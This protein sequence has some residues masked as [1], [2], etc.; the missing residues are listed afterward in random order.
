MVIGTQRKLDYT[1][2]RV[3]IERFI[4]VR[5]K[6]LD[7]GWKLNHILLKLG[8]YFSQIN[9]DEHKVG[10]S[11]IENVCDIQRLVGIGGVDKTFVIK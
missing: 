6:R 4:K 1:Y 8:R 3:G 5:V 9:T 10:R 7:T 11:W 2:Y